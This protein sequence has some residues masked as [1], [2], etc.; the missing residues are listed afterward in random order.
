[1]QRRRNNRGRQ[2]PVVNRVRNITTRNPRLEHRADFRGLVVRGSADPPR[3]VLS[4]WN[5]LVVSWLQTNGTTPADVC[6]TVANVFANMK[7]QLGITSAFTGDLV[8]RFQRADLWHIIPNGELNNE[9]VC[10]FRGLIEPS[11]TC[12]VELPLATLSDY[13]TPARNAN[14]HFIWPR[15]HS[16]VALISSNNFPVLDLS[17]R[18]SQQVL[19]HFHLLYN[20]PKAAVT[21][22]SLVVE[23]LVDDLSDFSIS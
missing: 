2:T 20:F 4:P 18:A 19:I 15:T 9:V 11:T 22:S 13:G 7:A 10:S 23:N 8:F 6:V 21:R 17:M 1:M 3:V 12:G 5:S 16:S 14:V